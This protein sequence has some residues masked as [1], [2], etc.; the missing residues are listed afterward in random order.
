MDNHLIMDAVIAVTGE[1]EVATEVV[2]VSHTCTIFGKT[3]PTKRSLSRHMERHNDKTVVCNVCSK[4]F[5][6]KFELQHMGAHMVVSYTCEVCGVSFNF[7]SALYNHTVRQH[8]DHTAIC[9]LCNKAFAT[10]IDNIKVKVK[11][12]K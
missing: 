10:K 1:L 2:E 8:R 12:T 3:C 5:T 7:K 9:I 11:V 6:T 4:S